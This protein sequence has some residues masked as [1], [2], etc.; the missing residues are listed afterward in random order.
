MRF[1]AVYLDF[2]TRREFVRASHVARSSWLQVYGYACALEKRGRIHACAGFA[3]REWLRHASVT[4]DEV[5]AVVDAGLARWDGDDLIVEGYDLKG[6]KT[7]KIIRANGGKGGRPPKVRGGETKSETKREPNRNRQ[8]SS[9]ETK[10]EPKGSP[11]RNPSSVSVSVSDPDPVRAEQSAPTEGSGRTGPADPGVEPAPRVVAPSPAGKSNEPRRTGQKPIQADLVASPAA[12]PDRPTAAARPHANG[13]RR[14]EPKRPGPPGKP[15]QP[16]EVVRK[17]HADAVK[18]AQQEK[19]AGPRT[20]E[21]EQF[22]EA[23]AELAKADPDPEVGGE[24]ARLFFGMDG[25][26]VGDGGWRKFGWTANQFTKQAIPDLLADAQKTVAEKR[27]QILA[28][29]QEAEFQ[30]G[31]AATPAPTEAEIARRQAERWAI[32]VLK[33]NGIDPDTNR[34]YGEPEPAAAKGSAP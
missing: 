9:R 8:V 29:E 19:S 21:P 6:E 16:V 25:R 5:Q 11:G 10:E 23:G 18:R 30:R 14:P 28:E 7:V 34:P 12:K 2:M 22:A 13:A 3:D 31:L 15:H 17:A 27:R 26:W 33:Q 4:C 20:W 1:A 24:V 32:R